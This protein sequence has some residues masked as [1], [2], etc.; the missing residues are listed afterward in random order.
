MQRIALIHL[1]WLLLVPIS[2]AVLVRS[3]ISPRPRRAAITI[4]V[5]LLV[6]SLPAVFFCLAISPLDF[7]GSAQAVRVSVSAPGYTVVMVQKPGTDFYDS[8]LEISR[9]DGKVTRLM[10]DCDANKWWGLRAKTQGTRTDFVTWLGT[11]VSSVDFADGT[12]SGSIDHRMYKLN[13]LD[14]KRTWSNG[15]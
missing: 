8:Y 15:G 1:L 3:A 7:L 13:E 6:L 5:T 10:V 2:A 14:F 12:V 9:A 11:V 4:G